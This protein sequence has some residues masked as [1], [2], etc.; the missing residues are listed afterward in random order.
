M[1]GSPMTK[2]HLPADVRRLLKATPGP[3]CSCDLINGLTAIIVKLD[4]LTIAGLRGPIPIGYRPELGLY[5]T[6]AAIRLV[7]DFYDHPDRPLGL[8]TF[9]DPAG[10]DHLRLLRTLAGQPQI[11]IHLFDDDTI[12]Y[13]YSKAITH[14]ETSRAE[15]RARIDQALAHTATIGRGDFNATKAA[16]MKDRPL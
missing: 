14:R 6:G 4:P 15:L 9:L 1:K 12:A 5:P 13:A 8:D 7:I 16:M 2:P 10:A 11:V 3:V